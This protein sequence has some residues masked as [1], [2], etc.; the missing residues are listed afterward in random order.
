MRSDSVH[1]LA[2]TWGVSLIFHV[3]LTGKGGLTS[4]PGSVYS[5]HGRAYGYDE[6]NTSPA[7]PSGN[8]NANDY[9]LY[10]HFVML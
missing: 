7:R 8:E 3:E 2:V 5:M 10:L 1:V 6:T 9:H 4:F